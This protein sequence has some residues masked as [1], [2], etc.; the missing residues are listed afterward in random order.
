MDEWFTLSELAEQ[1]GVPARTIRFYISRG[2]LNGPAGAGRAASYTRE[3]LER[4]DAIKRE[5][6]G[7]RTLA[8]IA[9]R[10]VQPNSDPE[11]VPAT[12][13]WQHMAADDVVVLARADVSPW[14]TKQIRAAIAEL[15]QKLKATDEK[16]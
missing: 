13:W 1:S 3:H 10:L 11:P 6:A 12:A 7:G 5:Q 15:A 8:D 4:L 9:S 2:L 16:E 14:R